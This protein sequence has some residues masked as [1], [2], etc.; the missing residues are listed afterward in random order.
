MAFQAVP[1]TVEIDVIYTLNLETVQNT[2]YAEFT[3]TYAQTDLD[4]LAAFVAT[5]IGTDWLPHQ[6]VEAVFVRVEVRGLSAEED[7]FAAS[8]LGAGAGEELAEALPNNVTLSIKKSS[9]FTGR[10]ARGR[11]YWIG[12]PSD[13]TSAPDEN[14]ITDTYR[15]EIVDAV[16]QIRT[17]INAQANWQA[18]LVSRFTGGAQRAEGKTFDWIGSVVVDKRVD[19]QRNRLP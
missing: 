6:P 18:V 7:F 3:G 17:T 16:D 10:S 15:D 19:T 2:F 13:K 1:N 11:C 9:A 4:S 12:I 5:K 14:H 8:V